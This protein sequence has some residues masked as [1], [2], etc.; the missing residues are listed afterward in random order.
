[1]KAVR[2]ESVGDD[3]FVIRATL[4]AGGMGV[5]YRAFDRQLG[6]EVALKKLRLPSG[7]ALYR[8]KR[9]FRALAD[10]VH[11][12]LVAL[13]ELHTVDDDWFFTMDLIEGVTF[14]DWVRIAPSH[15]VDESSADI[16]RP[17]SLRSRSDI[18]AAWL[19]LARLDTALAQLVDGVLALHVAGKLHRDLKPSNVLV[20]RDGR[21]VLLDFGLVADVDGAARAERT[22]EHAGAGTP[23]YMAPEQ[24][25]EAAPTPASDWY[26][27]G[28]ILYEALTGRRPFEGSSVEIMRAKQT[29]APVPPRERN[30]EVPPALDALCMR[31]LARDPAARPD[32]RAILTELGRAPSEATLQLQRTATARPFVGRAAERAALHQALEDAG[33]HTVAVFLRGESGIGKSRLVSQF[34]D[35][36]AGRVTALEGRCYQRESVPFKALD[37]VVDALTDELLAQPRDALRAGLPSEIA[38]LARLFPVLRRVPVIAERTVAA[39][40]PAAPQELRRRGLGALRA[41]LAWLAAR[42]RLAI[43]IDDLQWGDHDSAVFLADLV[44]HPDPLPLLLVLI[45]RLED[46]AGVIAAVRTPGPGLRGGDVRTVDLGPLGDDDARRL[47]EL[48]AGPA[49]ASDTLLRE[50][51][52]HPLFLLELARTAIAPEG[53]T[54]TL[55]GLIA[56]RVAALPAATAAL[57]RTLAVAARPLRRDDAADAAGV[58]EVDAPLSRLLAERL[59]R[60]RHLGG[61]AVLVELYHDRVR[62]AV[63]STA[64]AADLRAAHEGLVRVYE[65]AEAVGDFDALAAHSVGAGDR[66][67][68]A[69]YAAR[70]AENAE[71]ALAF[72]RAAELYAVALAHDGTDP[73]ERRRLLRRR[74][75][76]LA[77]GGR[78]DEAAAVFAE[79]ARTASGDDAL[80]LER[81][82]LEQLLRRGRL[83]DGMEQARQL[84]ARVGVALP[85]QRSGLVRELVSQ[86]VRRWF[87]GYHFREQPASALS[88]EQLRRIDLLQTVAM[89]LSVGDPLTGLCVQGHFLRAALEAGEPRRVCIALATEL[90]YLGLAGGRNQDRIDRLAGRVRQLADRVGDPYVTALATAMHGLVSFQLGRW[91]RARADLEAG[92]AALASHGTGS[93]WEINVGQHFHMSTL[94]Y[95]GQT[96]QLVHQVPLLLRDAV[97]RGDVYAQHALRAWRPNLT[98]LVIGQPDEARAHVLAVE[99]ERPAPEILQLRHYYEL[100]THVNIDL[101][102][103]D[104]SAGWQRLERAW[105]TVDAAHLLRIQSV[106]VE[107]TFLRARA[108]VAHALG[109]SPGR[110]TFLLGEAG[111]LV[112][113]LEA[114][115]V[116]WASGHAMQVR[117]M[118]AAASGAPRDALARLDDAA[119]IYAASSMELHA[120]VVQLRRGQLVAGPAGAAYVEAARRAMIDQAIADPDAIARLLCPWP[121]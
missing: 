59:V 106:R 19:N 81:L 45:H 83:P 6:H 27:V 87:R 15:D 108:I 89:A 116:W 53:P 102:V 30:P 91:R 5:V 52:G 92:V 25:T 58:A 114:E 55:D 24:A 39:P 48:E 112:R 97:E 69:R 65:R 104:A 9:E 119:Q 67:R 98:W 63:L 43:A 72:H 14:I 71:A 74:G 107:A 2:A 93:R 73:T 18:I 47:V 68:A 77:N 50:A 60:I 90:G 11:P 118:I 96:R 10:I 101:Y 35:E 84:L 76:A 36:I 20:T 51:G 23:A 94:F 121:A 85:A 111:R 88:A 86:R 100:A 46:D 78:L 3:R 33:D 110:R 4:G 113:D 16:T 49:L 42:R 40:L 61:D 70:G 64:S 22:D 75:V 115:H 80:E 79:A 120:A 1:M 29:E 28:A 99:A 8:F 17:A 109:V 41:L 21:V 82:R 66:V 105:P 95:A 31:L 44:H 54:A 26:A 32:G 117:A 34:L 12:N 56:R 13:H 38:A 7:R 62:D 57:L 37:G 103:G